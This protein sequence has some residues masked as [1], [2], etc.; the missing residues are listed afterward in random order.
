MSIT[1]EE[2]YNICYPYSP[3][4]NETYFIHN[5]VKVKASIALL[6]IGVIYVIVSTA[7]F[8]YYRR[9]SLI[10]SISTIAVSYNLV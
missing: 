8:I 9:V 3:I 6:I 4:R 7:R 2:R 10:L 5:E 1:E